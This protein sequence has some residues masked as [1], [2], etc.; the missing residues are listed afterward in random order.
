MLHSV[1]NVSSCP[2]GCSGCRT[3]QKGLAELRERHPLLSVT[4]LGWVALGWL[5]GTHPP[6]HALPLQGKG[7]KMKKP[8]GE[9]KD[10]EINLRISVIDKTTWGKQIEFVAN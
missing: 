3:P 6:I 1:G 7:E 8:M 4:N 2:E 9:D 5:T 10:R